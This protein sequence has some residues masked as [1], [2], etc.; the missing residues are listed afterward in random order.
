MK[1]NPL[2]ELEKAQAKVE[3]ERLGRCIPIAN[4]VLQLIAASDATMGDLTDEQRKEPYSDL[5]R[6]I[7]E[8]MADKNIKFSEKDL[9]F[10]L[11]AQKI[12]LARERTVESLKRSFDKALEL[13][14][15]GNYLDVHLSDIDDILLG[16]KTVVKIPQE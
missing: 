13:L 9:V 12:D 3:D 8:L 5:A 6:K 4:E 2:K 10:Q 16:R 7:L 1:K 14:L 11:I 15:G